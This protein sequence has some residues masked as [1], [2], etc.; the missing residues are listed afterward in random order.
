[1]TTTKPTPEEIKLS[2]LKAAKILFL[3]NGIAA[4]EM[5]SIASEAGLSRST[6]YRYMIDKNQLAFLIADEVLQDLTNKSI[7][8]TSSEELD[9]YGKL[10]QYVEHFARTL[11]ENVSMI[12]FLSEFDSIFRGDYPNIPEADDYVNTINRMLHRSAQFL[13]EG[14]ADG[15]IR[16]L[17]DPLFYTSILINTLFGLAERMLPRSSH[18]E[19]EH[20]ASAEKVLLATSEILLS[21]IKGD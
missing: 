13:F 10:C 2:L 5:K 21:H 19:K 15:S 16:P 4:T 8:F 20:N 11:C 9:G 6:L 12:S 17:P 1:M 3:R 7:A 14:L 18:Y